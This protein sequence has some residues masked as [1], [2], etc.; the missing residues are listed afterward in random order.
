V[1]AGDYFPDLERRGEQDALAR[2]VSGRTIANA[3]D[4]E[5]PKRMSVPNAAVKTILRN[6]QDLVLKLLKWVAFS[7]QDEGF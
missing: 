6:A 3:S 4:P 5:L 2:L 1:G 7:G